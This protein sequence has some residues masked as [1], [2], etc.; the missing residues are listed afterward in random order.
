MDAIP[1]AFR[2]NLGPNTKLQLNAKAIGISRS[3]EQVIITLS[4][5]EEPIVADYCIST[6]AP[7]L[8]SKILDNSISK[9][10]QVSLSKITMVPAFKFGWQ[11]RRRFWE[12]ENEIYGGISCTKHI[13]SQL[14]Y[15][16]HGLLTPKGVLI[17]A[18]TFGP[19]AAI[20]GAMSHQERS[21]AALRGGEKLH[22][23]TF[24][25]NV[26]KGLSIAWQNMPYQAGGWAFY[27]NQSENP[28]YLEITKPQGRLILAGDYLSYLPG[29]MEGAIQSAELAVKQI[30]RPDGD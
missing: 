28:E 16:S 9:R 24:R 25:R 12:E 5:S 26:D 6:M 8:L 3:A 1:L 30:I 10:F 4:R 11:A 15:P 23:D 21:A 27:R 18:Y 19:D 2:K 13:I 20:L 14:W 7:P 17:G 22:P 29:W